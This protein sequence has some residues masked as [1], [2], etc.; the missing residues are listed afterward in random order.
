[1]RW[2]VDIYLHD[3]EPVWGGYG[4]LKHLNQARKYA[5][6]SEIYRPTI[7]DRDKLPVVEDCKD[8]DAGIEDGEDEKK[9]VESVSHVDLEYCIVICTAPYCIAVRVGHFMNYSGFLVFE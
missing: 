9:I 1:M 8:D 4:P 5:I 2:D 6:Y 7:S 3:I